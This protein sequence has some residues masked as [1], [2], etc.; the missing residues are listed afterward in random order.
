MAE[1]PTIPFEGPKTGGIQSGL[2]SADI[3]S[4]YTMLAE[5]LKKT[6]AAADEVAVSLAEQAGAKAV[7][8]DANGNVQ[9]DHPVIIG[10]AAKA[11]HDSV[12][13]ASLAEAE[14][15]SRLKDV[16][17]RKQY[18]DNPQGYLQAAGTFSK[19]MAAQY[20]K[21]SGDAVL[22]LAVRKQIDSMTTTT[23]RG[24]ANEHERLELHRNAAT[25]NAE[26]E[27]TT[28]QMYGMAN[29]GVTSGLEWDKLKGKVDTIYNNFQS[30]PRMGIPKEQID[31]DKAKLLDELKVR[32]L[33]YHITDTYANAKDADGNK[34][35]RDQAY[36]NAKAA[37]DTILTSRQLN[38]TP[39]QRQSY[40]TR[41]MSDLNDRARAD[42]VAITGVS[43][44]MGQ[45]AETALKGFPISPEQMANMET[46]V[47]QNGEPSLQAQMDYTKQIVSQAQTWSHMSPAQLDATVTQMRAAGAP[48]P[49]IQ[50]AEKMLENMRKEIG[51][52]PVTWANK[53]GTFNVPT[54]Q[55]GP[56][57]P[58]L[59]DQMRQRAATVEAMARHYGISPTYLR[60]DEKT[61]LIA[62]AG[63][64]G[65]VPVAQA[66]AQGFGTAA[67]KV[68]AQLAPDAPALAHLGAL[69]MAGGTQSF[70]NDAD[71][72]SRYRT[73][74]EL[75]KTLPAWLKEPTRETYAAQQ[76]QVIDTY[77]NSMYLMKAAE[78]GL[79]AAVDDAFL[80]RA[81]RNNLDPQLGAATAPAGTT[82][83]KDVFV[84]TLQEAAG[85][86]II[87]GMQ[88][89]GVGDYP[90][91]G[92]T[93]FGLQW[94]S[95]RVKVPPD[96]RADK[97]KD[98]IGKI[99]DGDLASLPSPPI[100]PQTNKVYTARDLQGMMPYA[101]PNGRY[102][103]AI[104][105]VTSNDAKYMTNAN[106]G[107]FELDFNA[108]A[109]RLRQRL[110]G[111][112]YG[113]GETPAPAATGERIGAR[114]Q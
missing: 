16:D 92:N 114:G 20:E 86:R 102:N 101:L 96:V 23:Y 10:P 77:G 41:I 99:N 40:H 112:F 19:T 18:V 54:F 9:I 53:T 6:G 93:V 47:Q 63:S 109:P 84:R 43:K 69:A 45:V 56:D 75:A 113:G 90:T 52:D 91:P 34:L 70:L 59:A 48:M 67:P 65:K 60:D 73:D 51:S 15:A 87:D 106:G 58:P 27:Y 3:S 76:A 74:K 89:G 26:L 103:F 13:L 97:F 55:T 30:N 25:L 21:A 36:A 79:R 108:L 62:M 104:G 94:G 44:Q 57:A 37:A 95:S 72:G 32:G 105:D 107:R 39:A 8:T 49:V 4:P 24:L 12:K 98:V 31:Q 11:F 7:T 80:E 88:Y 5:N 38:L 46:A 29:G 28:N 35:P 42:E 71:A 14:Q 1:L 81:R 83:G 2:S 17:L 50:G 61:A 22:G 78:T 111:A 68:L 85:A 66:I 64:V 33:G 100:N 82:S 110:P